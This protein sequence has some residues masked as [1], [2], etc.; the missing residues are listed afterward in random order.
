MGPTAALH[1]ADPILQAYGLGKFDDASSASVS[2]HLESCESCRQ[3][4]AELSSDD[5]LCR[6]QQAKFMPTGQFLNGRHPPNRHR[7]RARVSRCPAC[8][9]RHPATGAGRPP[10]LENHPRARTFAPR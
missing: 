3:R 6:L 1:P 9:G 4:V 2:Q 7:T 10:R 5:F 8:A